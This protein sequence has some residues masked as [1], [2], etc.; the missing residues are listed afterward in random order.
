MELTMHKPG[1]AKAGTLKVSD[2][3]FAVDFNE[4][5]IHHVLTAFM[6]GSRSG[7]KAQ[8]T[9]AEVRGG[10]RKPWKQKGLGKA[11]AGSSRSPIWRGGGATFAAKNRDFSQKVNRK[12]Y[13]GAIRSILS[14]LARQDR[15][16]CIESFTLDSPKTQAALE[17]LGG[18]GL[19][20]VLIITEA[21]TENAYLATRNIPCVNLI[22]MAEINPYCLIGYEKVLLTKAAVE[23]VE[24][25]LS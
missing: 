13:R 14:E 16:L 25:W 12:M 1:D 20:E 2:A 10:G 24:A 17:L 8:K 15:L 3:I 18:L 22:D 9:R 7:T 4:P 11:R 23:K 5:L 21:V 19:R 6:A